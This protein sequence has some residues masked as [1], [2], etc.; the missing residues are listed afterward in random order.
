MAL[1]SSD[2]IDYNYNNYNI[3][4]FLLPKKQRRERF[5]ILLNILSNI[6]L[7]ASDKPPTDGSHSSKGMGREFLSAIFNN[8]S[9]STFD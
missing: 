2:F 6:S 5:A 9:L 8:L 3:I 4:V 7:K 1:D